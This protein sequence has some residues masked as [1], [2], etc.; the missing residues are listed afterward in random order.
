MKNFNHHWKSKG[1]SHAAI[2]LAYVHFV[3]C[4]VSFATN[5]KSKNKTPTTFIMLCKNDAYTRGGTKK[6]LLP[7]HTPPRAEIL[8]TGSLNLSAAALFYVWRE[9]SQQKGEGFFASSEALTQPFWYKCEYSFHR[10]R[11]SN[12]LKD[13]CI[14]NLAKIHPICQNSRSRTCFSTQGH[15]TGH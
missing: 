12:S 14:A 5:V 11:D 9:I 15:Q 2:I 8:A 6:T 1:N 10:S 4:L 7:S 13:I 3:V